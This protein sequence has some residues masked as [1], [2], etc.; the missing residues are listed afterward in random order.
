MSL[1][2]GIRNILC[3]VQY[4]DLSREVP[5]TF[6][7]IDSVSTQYVRT[8]FSDYTQ[9]DTLIAGKDV[10]LI[11]EQENASSTQLETVG[12]AWASTLDSFVASGGVVIQCDF[13]GRYHI[14]PSAG[15]LPIT[16]SS[17]ITDALL[18][19]AD[20]LDP[21]AS[22]VSD[23]LA[24]NGSS[25]YSCSEGNVVAKISSNAPV[26]INKTHGLGS[27]VAIGHDYFESSSN[28]DRIVGNAV[29]DLPPIL[30]DLNLT[31]PEDFDSTGQTGGPFTPQ[32][33]TYTL[34][35]RGSSDVVWEA[36][37]TQTWV[38]VS[39]LGGTITPG[40]TTNVELCINDEAKGFPKGN[41]TDVFS[42][43]NTASGYIQTRVITLDIYPPPPIIR[44][45]VPNPLEATLYQD[46]QVSFTP[47]FTIH[48]DG[49]DDLNYTINI[50]YGALAAGNEKSGSVR[51]GTPAPDR[52]N[53]ALESF[54]ARSGILEEPITVSRT[55][56]QGE[57]REITLT[58]PEDIA[59]VKTATDL[60]VKTASTLD[61]AI[62]GADH[63]D[64]MTDVQ[65]KLLG[66][67]L[68][69]S[70]S[71][72]DVDTAT[73]TLPELQVFDS[74]IVYQNTGYN[75]PNAMGNV[76]ADYADAGGG[77]VSMVYEI[78][79]ALN[80]SL[81]GRWATGGY[82]LMDRPNNVRGQ[83][84]LGTV[85]DPTHPIMAGVTSFDGGTNSSRP[86]ATTVYAGVTRI[87]DWSDGRPLVA[88]KEMGGVP[89]AAVTFFPPSS[90]SGSGSWNP[91]T[92]GDL[93]MGNALCWVA[94]SFPSGWLTVEEPLTGTIAGSGNEEK[95]VGMDST[96]MDP[97]IYDA[98]IR[99]QSNDPVNPTVEV[100]AK[101]T[102][103]LDDLLITPGEA[104]SSRGPKGGPFD[105]S[106]KTYELKNAG[107]SPLEWS[108]SVKDNWL[109]LSLSGGIL[110]PG[111]KIS[112]VLELTAQAALLPGGTYESGVTFTNN[113]SGVKQTRDASLS[114][115]SAATMP[116][117]EDFEGGSPLDPYWKITGTAEYRT[118]VTSLNDPHGG[119]YHL[120]MDD[121]IMDS[122]YSRNE[123][124]L[125]IDLENYEN[126]SLSFFAREWGDEAH[127]PPPTPFTGGADF[128]GVAV[129]Q[130][131][132]SW[133]EIQDLR[134]LSSSYS[135]ITVNLDSAVSAHGLSYN[136]TFK[137]RF[138]QYDNYPI[139]S[140]GIGLDDIQITGDVKD[141]M[142]VTPPEHL[143]SSGL[144]GGPFDPPSK[145]YT[146]TNQ[147]TASIDW[148]A[149]R[150]QNWIDVDP[151][152]GALGTGESAVVTVS[153]S[154]NAG[155]LAPG[156]YYDNVLFTN[157]SSGVSQGRNV[158]LKVI[159]ITGEIEVTDSI[160]PPDDLAMPFGPVIVGDSRSEQITITNTD[161]SHNLT[162]TE[163][164]L[165]REY[166]ENFDDGQAQ[167]WD[168]DLTDNWKVVSGEYRAATAVED[169]MT[170]T[171][172]GSEWDDLSVEMKCRR[173]GSTTKAASVVLRASADFD[174]EIGSGYIF[175]INTSGSYAVWKQVGG[176]WSWLQSWIS[177]SS[178]VPG[179]NTLLASAMGNNLTFY[180]NGAPVW[181]GTDSTLTSGRIGLMGFSGGD[182]IHFFDDVKVTEPVTT[183]VDI[184]EEQEWYNNHPLG[185]GDPREC[186]AGNTAQTFPELPE[187][188]DNLLPRLAGVFQI[189]DLSSVLPLTLG[190][191]EDFSFDVT[192]TPQAYQADEAGVVIKSNDFDEPE[193]EVLLSG[194]GVPDLLGV[195]PV[196]GFS[197]RGHPGGP[198]KP[199]STDY[200]LENNGAIPMDWEIVNF[201][202]WITVAPKSGTLPTGGSTNV[203]VSFAAPAYTLPVGNHTGKLVF[204]NLNSG[205]FQ[206]RDVRLE[207]FTS[208]EIRV[209]PDSLLV[210]LKPEQVTTRTL[211]IGN[212][213][214]GDLEF[215]LK[216]RE[217]GRVV[218]SRSPAMTADKSNSLVMEYSFPSPVADERGDYDLFTMEGL[219]LYE[220]EGAPA[221]PVKPVQILIPYGKELSDIRVTPLGIEDLPGTYHLAPGERPFPLSHPELVMD[222]TP[223]PAIYEQ[224]TPWPG[225]DFTDA[226]IHSRR[227]YRICYLNLFPLQY[228]PAAGRVSCCSSMLVEISFEERSKPNMVKPSKTVLEALKRSVDNPSSLDSYNPA[229]IDNV[230]GKMG[231]LPP[232]GPYKYIIITS[233]ALKG[234]AAPYNF[235]ALRD[236]KTAKGLP[237]T[238]ITTEWIY[239]NYDGTRPSGGEDDQTRIRNFLIEA[240]Q[241][242]GTEYVLLGGGNPIVPARMFWVQAADETDTMPVDMYYGC[243]DPEACTFDSDGDG[244]YGEPTDGVGGAD[245]DLAAE[246]YVG[247]ATVENAT[248]LANF[249]RKTFAYDATN[250]EY[251]PRIA[252]LGE[253]LGFGGVA[254]YAK[255]AMEQIRLG[256]DYDGYITTGF[257][258]HTRIDF[259][260]FVTEDCISGVCWPLYDKDGSWPKADL[261][262]LMNS[263][264]HVFN[265][266]GHANETYC[267]KL[268]TSSLSSLTNT[269]SFFVYSQGCM[270][271]WFDK[272][273]CFADVITTMEQGAFAVVM[274]ARYGWG[275]RNSTDG[276][277]QRFDRQFWD[278]VLEEDML[279]LG[280][281]NQDSK[282]DNL[283]DINGSCIRWCC[284]E[285]NLFGDPEQEFRFPE[286][287]KW[288]RV[289][290]EAGKVAP[291]TDSN[292]D[293]GFYA[294]NLANGTYDGEIIISSNDKD[295]PTT[296]VKVTMVISE[297]DLMVSP[298]TGLDSM[299]PEGMPFEFDPLSKSYTVTN[300]G[301][302][303]LNWS[304]EKTADWIDL[305]STG[306]ILAPGDTAALDIDINALAASQAAGR[307]TTQVTFT[308]LGNGYTIKR[309][310]H[311]DV[312][313]RGS[314]HLFEWDGISSP[315]K[316]GDPI[317]V[318]ITARDSVGYTAVSFESTV[319]LS[320][321]QGGLA[322][323]SSIVI[324][325]CD[326]NT[327]DV[328]EIQNVSGGSV[329]TSGW[330][331]AISDDYS[332]INDVNSILWNLPDS[333]AEGEILYKTDYSSDNYW[334]SNMFWNNTASCWAMIVDDKG[335]VVDFVAWGWNA[336]AISG[337][338]PT[339]NG[340]S[341][342]IGDKWTG[343]AVPTGGTGS[344]QRQGD[345]DHDD[346]TD[347]IWSSSTSKGVQNSGLTVPFTGG[348]IPI[349]ITPDTSGA[350]AAGEWQGD[351]AVIETGKGVILKADDGSGHTG[352]GDPFDVLKTTPT[353]TPT[354]TPS[355]DKILEYLLGKPEGIAEDCNRDGCVDVSD[356]L[357]RIMDGR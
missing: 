335:R 233:E 10:L 135:Q 155:S 44:V 109:G 110:D 248:E 182:C 311:L 98:T 250:A 261:I 354:P 341:I 343:D 136:S 272:S 49:V 17:K 149:T 320:A 123:L 39:P 65:T 193:V 199:Q 312:I 42:V 202:S 8:D 20:P 18:T 218:L 346:S 163:I 301:T 76:L 185:G 269:D 62:C 177:S 14:L 336:S 304:V 21:V 67:G 298:K 41:Y 140:D 274:N 19:I 29:F 161:P 141:D 7:A 339:I 337:M 192:Y 144:E 108:A 26:V 131:G 117:I 267:M 282:E 150:S 228:T 55:T 277:S 201:P 187:G 118:Q 255:N 189:P 86:E 262:T 257:E 196:T 56:E 296:R 61:V 166:F 178:I 342:T 194:E 75:D 249:I 238:I 68:F 186:P 313:A 223:D 316:A 133:Y 51:G 305:S 151:A 179:T 83:S 348:R 236:S 45:V 260:D 70:V 181:S 174:D 314:A 111:E 235:Q 208:A 137:I 82:V 79:G 92:N 176:S 184:G 13:A 264:I 203:R 128:D 126:V 22:G 351:V 158:T 214:D 50:G 5:N 290:P 129:S 153:F 12:T 285:L 303:P 225:K 145:S 357:V 239:A 69:N 148:E 327:P 240:Y 340:F 197:S 326:P 71:I 234:A 307:H 289:N 210:R 353:P 142:V 47:G 147:G 191:G 132:T 164:S 283:W 157:K 183:P 81:G 1:S 159:E 119:S 146:L 77:V 64:Y 33:K 329:N 28:Q 52:V 334:G 205:H 306:G 266:L 288:L 293:V 308:N 200:L 268:N 263:G 318:K 124:T 34:E 256:G 213:G 60:G 89:L 139:S 188:N 355:S 220:R 279:Q 91:A 36:S 195:S 93:L 2:V 270:P 275:K 112:V 231:A 310:V 207:V 245:V 276:P 241:N 219:E 27:V 162:V 121:F 278:A 215:S 37:K 309:E 317:N 247:R 328:L 113:T 170:A 122:T 350:F 24:G 330:V 53:E 221:V 73:P 95:D 104:L 271:G 66:T 6:T 204:R 292:V 16:G 46:Q 281:A 116:F 35:N 105:P 125:T 101:L 323:S 99:I 38:D 180:I 9:L 222:L 294:G 352:E 168:E 156:D 134:T 152:S 302:S 143:F 154:A 244:R 175:Q 246:I 254:E 138:N 324:T 206:T 3:Y 114:V 59:G 211:T 58:D 11:P 299:G 242:W 40:A 344:I 88:V 295:T 198:F 338:N 78:G 232:G 63:L 349:T 31:P 115:E 130:D 169:F 54:I 209:D 72:V 100:P 74:V 322:G 227:G 216:T 102:V 347:F 97:G 173:S 171:Y 319:N 106:S 94:G 259:I 332:V 226:G 333:M 325:E 127:G 297:D 251:L 284:Y 90:D 315:Q 96:G 331:V 265:H 23:Y 280:R 103:L 172:A 107:T 273:N 212:A 48:N 224:D 190:P 217:T 120:T 167:N 15:L 253:H 321:T 25:S 160:P 345:E 165:G 300:N 286:K 237:A 243:L 32:C 87:A 84:Y 356:L 252:M 85:H 80:P 291:S 258:N 4:G 230:K 57:T 43:K 287:C 30:D 229:A